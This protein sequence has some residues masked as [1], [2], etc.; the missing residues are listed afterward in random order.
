M[1]LALDYGTKWSVYEKY[2]AVKV[3]VIN[4]KLSSTAHVVILDMTE[5]A[6]KSYSMVSRVIVQ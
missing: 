6:T 5:N 3:Q 4:N 1:L 2:K